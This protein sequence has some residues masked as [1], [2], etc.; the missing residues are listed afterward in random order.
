MTEIKS[1][2]IDISETETECEY[3]YADSFDAK[4]TYGGNRLHKGCDIMDRS[5]TRGKIKIVSMCDGKIE[6]LGWNE[7][8]GWR[9][10]IRS[11]N[12]NYYYISK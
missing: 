10:G 7:K 2:P 8:G 3:I 1:F 12:G 5:N 4:R 11:K 9:I 6:K